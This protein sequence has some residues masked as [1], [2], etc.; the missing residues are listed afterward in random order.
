MFFL[1]VICLALGIGFF[2]QGRR[3]HEP[4][5]TAFGVCLVF[6]AF[7]TGLITFFALNTLD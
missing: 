5:M 4:R 3:H 1:P 6:A 2:I 7:G